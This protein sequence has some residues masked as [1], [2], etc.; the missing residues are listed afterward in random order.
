[1]LV[2]WLAWAAM[3]EDDEGDG[4]MTVV[5][6]GRPVFWLIADVRRGGGDGGDNFRTWER[7]RERIG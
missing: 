1:M 3:D 2:G 6:T 5:K 7:D 4:E